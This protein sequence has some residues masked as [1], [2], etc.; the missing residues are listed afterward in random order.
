MNE[1]TRA[2]ENTVILG[3]NHVKNMSPPEDMYEDVDNNG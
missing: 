2:Y 1:L 3:E